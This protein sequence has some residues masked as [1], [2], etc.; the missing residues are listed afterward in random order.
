MKP[1]KPIMSTDLELL[2]LAAKA[3]GYDYV[4]PSDDGDAVLLRGVQQPWSPLTDDGDAFRLMAKLHLDIRFNHRQSDDGYA[5][6]VLCQW[7]DTLY[8][9]SQE[10]ECYPYAATR[11]AIVRVA[12]AIGRSLK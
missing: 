11:L 7:A 5:V 2:E 9:D 4:G 8:C 1:Q 10:F 6:D 12:A 3:A